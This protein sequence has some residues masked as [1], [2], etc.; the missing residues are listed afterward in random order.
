M[1]DGLSKGNEVDPPGEFERSAGVYGAETQRV[2]MQSVM[3]VYSAAFT[4]T[5]APSPL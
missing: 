4:W 5:P 1:S 3:L 2:S